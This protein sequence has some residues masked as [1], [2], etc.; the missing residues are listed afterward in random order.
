MQEVSLDNYSYNICVENTNHKEPVY[1][2]GC[3]FN[4][5]KDNANH[6][7]LNTFREE[8]ILAQLH[9]LST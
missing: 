8:L 6:F 5:I 2:A 1:L 9:C 4:S 3:Y 7:Y